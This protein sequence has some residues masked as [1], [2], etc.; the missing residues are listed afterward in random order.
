MK[1]YTLEEF[2][3]FERDEK[4]RRICPTGDY[5]AI[6]NFDGQNEFGDGCVFRGWSTFGELN[7]FGNG[8]KFGTRCSFGAWSGFDDKCDFGDACDFGV[9]CSFWGKSSFGESCSFGRDCFFGGRNVF[10]DGACFGEACDFF[11]ESMYC[12]F[13]FNRVININGLYEYPIRI[14]LNNS[15][16]FLSVGCKNFATLDEAREESKN[17]NEN[18]EAILEI[19]EKVIIKALG[20]KW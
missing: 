12:L 11:G 19:V 5:T 13:E 8:C 4:G 14:Y 18:N 20:G 9:K 3:K 17:R 1:K 10:S 2:E 7:N 6:E 15:E 16:Y